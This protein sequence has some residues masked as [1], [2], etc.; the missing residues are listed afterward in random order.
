VEFTKQNG[1]IEYAENKMVEIAREA[2]QFIDSYVTEKALKDSFKAYLDY[3][4]QRCY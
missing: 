2:Q 4:I 1:G 3:V